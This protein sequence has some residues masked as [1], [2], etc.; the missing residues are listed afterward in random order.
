MHQVEKQRIADLEGQIK[1]AQLKVLEQK[2]KTGGVNASKENDAMI[3]K[4]IQLLEN[5]LNKELVKF[6]QAL[7]EVRGWTRAC[8][9]QSLGCCSLPYIYMHHQHSHT[10]TQNKGLRE[11]IDRLR[12]DRVIFDNVYKRLERC[13]HEKKNEMVRRYLICFVPS[14]GGWENGCVPCISKPRRRQ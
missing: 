1:D 4:Q 2:Q 10:H 8:L 7:A 12:K 5:R 9:Y 3:A 6:N 13:L 14:V 11:R